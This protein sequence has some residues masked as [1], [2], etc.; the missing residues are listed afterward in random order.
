MVFVSASR[1]KC[2]FSTFSSYSLV[3][4]KEREIKGREEERRKKR[5]I[6][7]TELV[8]LKGAE[9]IH[10]GQSESL[11]LNKDAILPKDTSL[12]HFQ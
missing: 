4:K 9:I 7:D 1:D 8:V 11:N 2:S 3:E 12:A 10:K 5:E 6:T